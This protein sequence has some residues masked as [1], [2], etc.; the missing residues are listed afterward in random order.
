MKKIVPIALAMMMAAA[1]AIANAY[2]G[3]IDGEFHGWEGETIYKL[4]DGHVIQ[5]AEY[6]YHYHYAY[7][8]HVIIFNSPSG[9]KIQVIGDDDQPIRITILK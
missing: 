5:Q 9:L 4:M 1:S 8:P 3:Q 2:E 6:H 7:S